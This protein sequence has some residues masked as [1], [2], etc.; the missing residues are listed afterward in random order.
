MDKKGWIKLIVNSIFAGICIAF[1][2]M[3]FLY[4]SSLALP[5]TWEKAVGG[6]FF[7]FGLFFIIVMEY[8]L[9]TGMVAGASDMKPKE[10]PQL[11]VCYVFNTLGILFICALAFFMDN[12]VTKAVMEK[13]QGVMQSKL[14]NTYVSAFISACF[15]GMMI[16]FA[17]KSHQKAR[18]KGL[19]GTLGILFPVLLFV[20][21]GFEHCI[22]NQTYIFLAI[23]NG[24]EIEAGRLLVFAIVT[25]FGNIVGGVFFPVI[26]KIVA[27]AK[28][29]ATPP[30]AEDKSTETPT[31]ENTKTE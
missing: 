13:A 19:S 7:G 24:A 14:S 23:F 27:Y 4:S 22:A 21:M 12:G 28:N 29:K 30:I 5:G 10:W 17:V 8:K 18:A 9:F 31:A 6:L 25:A 3:L 15:C 16:T 26:E 1:A 11:I 2:G 20:Y